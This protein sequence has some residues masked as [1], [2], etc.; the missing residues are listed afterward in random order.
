MLLEDRRRLGLNTDVPGA[1][2]AIIER[3]SE[4]VRTA[5]VI[6]GG[7]TATSLLLVSV[8]ATT[9]PLGMAPR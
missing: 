4:P 5:V 2:S 9:R 1:V 8:T 6:G 3:V 7:A